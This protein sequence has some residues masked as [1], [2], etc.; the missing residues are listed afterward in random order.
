MGLLS[1]LH[2]N[3]EVVLDLVF[4]PPK[5]WAEF[6]RIEGNLCHRC[7]Y[8]FEAPQNI[9]IQKCSNC[10]DLTWYLDRAFSCYWMEGDP[11]KSVLEFKYHRQFY[12]RRRLGEALFE[13][14]KTIYRPDK[15]EALVPVPLHFSKQRDRGFNQAEELALVLSPKVQLPV[16]NCL[17]RKRE[18]LS[19]VSQDREKRLKNPQGSFEM[20]TRFDV[21]G[22]SLLIIDDVLTTGTTANECARVLREAG[23][24][25]VAVLTVAR[26]V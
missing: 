22:R 14:F 24:R 8:P 10:S 2:Q 12:W 19:Q 3:L 7:G 21:R 1:T 4:P 6:R 23:A 18:T 26:G 13:G 11:R 5:P 17:K 20:T 16:W 25:S 15:F 9:Q